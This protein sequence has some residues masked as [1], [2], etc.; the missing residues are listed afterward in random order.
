MKQVFF[1]LAMLSIC[2]MV[3]ADLNEKISMDFRDTDVRE[4]CKVLA[5]R[6]GMGIITEKSV[7]GQLNISLKN[8]TVRQALDLVSDASG[9]TWVMKHGAV[10]LTDERKLGRELKVINLKH[11]SAEEVAKI[12]SISVHSDLKIA[13]CT[14]SNS[15]IV[16][17]SRTAI[18]D[19]ML[20]VG[21]IDKPGNYIKA[22]LKFMNGAQVLEKIDFS[23][24]AGENFKFSEH[25]KF[26]PVIE[27]KKKMFSVLA[28]NCEL[29]IGSIASSGLLDASI[30]LDLKKSDKT[31]GN[32]S[33]AS[34]SGQFQAE[35]GKTTQ[36]LAT[37]EFD[38]IKV[39][40]TWVK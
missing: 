26:K 16:N 19:A 12:I 40:F 1:L 28:M 17:G 2:S 35:K 32:E 5:S 10:L 27:G 33:N 7:R 34:Y 13:T 11:I 39:I 15:V 29:K 8:L 36:V 9:F 38:S 24:K 30:I 6:A 21:H 37:S 18:N 3:T 23:V 22:S 14:D 4:I 25:F 31:A 20:I